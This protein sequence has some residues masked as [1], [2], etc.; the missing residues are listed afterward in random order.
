MNLH[1]LHPQQQSKDLPLVILGLLLKVIN[2]N[3]GISVESS[4]KQFIPDLILEIP[5]LM[6]P[7]A[8]T[9]KPRST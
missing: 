3:W 6:T 8:L 5:D 2:L 9:C 4:I 1:L 7:P